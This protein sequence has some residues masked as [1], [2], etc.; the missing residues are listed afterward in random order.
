MWSNVV[1]VS[2]LFCGGIAAVASNSDGS[3]RF[4]VDF[5]KHAYSAWQNAILAPIA[6]RSGLAM[7]HHVAIPDAA[8]ILRDGLYLPGNRSEVVEQTKLMMNRVN[9]RKSTLE[10][11]SRVYLPDA[12]L[13]PELV[14]HLRDNFGTGSEIVNFAEGSKVAERVNTWVNESSRGM[15]PEFLKADELS[16]DVT[17]LLINVMVMNASWGFFDEKKTKKQTFHFLNGDHEVDMM[18]VDGTL[19]R[20]YLEDLMTDAIKLPYGWGSDLSMVILLP[21]KETNLEHVIKH[22]TADHY[23]QLVQLD[24]EDEWYG[25][26][27][28]GV[29]RFKVE[30]KLDAQTTL[31]KMGLKTLF[32]QEAFQVLATR[33][34]KLGQVKQSAFIKVDEKGT[35]AAAA[36]AIQSD[37]ISGPWNIDVDRPFMYIIRKES[38][39]DILFIGHYSNYEE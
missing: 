20:M 17:S 19:P 35:Q 32:G 31:V 13:N 26:I 11:L 6:I 39:K 36:A 4:A 28:L 5:F 30:Q 15:I 3:V 24:N 16:G 12:P 33:L 7:M 14:A 10:M 1:V 22:F 38:T 9:E 27:R 29:P 2:V 25:N 23:K 34:S 37:R 8:R 21:R 18:K